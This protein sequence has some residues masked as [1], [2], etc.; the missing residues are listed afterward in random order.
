M[1]AL[2]RHHQLPPCPALRHLSPLID[3]CFLSISVAWPELGVESLWG[4]GHAPT[5]KQK[6]LRRPLSGLTSED[7]G[8]LVLGSSE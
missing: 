4:A 7:S 3:F 2:S 5:E 8:W 1:N 6:E